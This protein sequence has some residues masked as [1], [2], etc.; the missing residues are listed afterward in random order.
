MTLKKRFILGVFMCLFA[1]ILSVKPAYASSTVEGENYT[2]STAYNMGSYLNLKSVTAILPA[3]EKTSYFKFTV[4]SN[5]KIYVRCSRDKAYTGM[6]LSLRDSLDNPITTRSNVYDAS[7]L[8]PF[9]AVDCDGAKDGQTFYVRVERGTYDIDKP[10]YFSI[11]L[12]NRIRSGSG[13]F[14]F[15]GTAFN[16]GNSSMSKYGV[17]SSVIKVDLSNNTEIP[18]GAIVKRASTSSRQTPR[19]G[20]VKH[21]LMPKSEKIW[22]ESRTSSENSGS[23]KISESDLIAAKQVWQFKYNAKALKSSKM[24]DV[25]LTLDWTYDLANTNYKIVS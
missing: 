13:T 7:T 2:I 14:D 8:T 19:Q 12:N 4:N 22:Y 18:A 25:K 21:F 10:M 23:Y 17:D 20:N 11:T 3:R 16:S 6:A 5:D 24:T 1:V 9:M 15:I